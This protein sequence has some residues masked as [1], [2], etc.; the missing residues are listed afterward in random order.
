MYSGS[1]PHEISFRHTCWYDLAK[2][3]QSKYLITPNIAVGCGKTDAEINK[4]KR[5]LY[6][7]LVDK[8]SSSQVLAFENDERDGIYAYYSLYRGFRL[9]AGL[10]QI[11]KREFLTRPPSA[12]NEAEVYD[13]II[14]WER[15]V[16]EQ[17]KLVPAVQRPILSKTIKG[18][19]LKKI[20]VRSNREYIKT[21]EAITDS[22]DLRKEVLQMAMFNRTEKNSQA[23]KPV[24]MDLNAVMEKLKG[25]LSQ[26]PIKAQEPDFNFGEG[27]GQ[28]GSLN[29]IVI[30][31][32]S[33]IDKFVVEINAMMKGKGK[34][35]SRVECHN[36]GKTGHYARDC[37]AAKGKGDQKGSQWG[38]QGHP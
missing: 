18:A 26:S 25:Q 27:K 8:C 21:H 6:T 15:E 20:A 36:C 12:K 13:C 10:G 3:K 23:N 7:V 19:V 11:E 4:L 33:D 35:E 30:P 9:T 37:W 1:V 31:D 2:Q 14:T 34:G 28:S 22:D 24:P 17:E 29:S 32:M 16:K 5:D 38:F